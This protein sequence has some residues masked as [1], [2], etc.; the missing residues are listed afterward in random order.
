M[1]TVKKKI[2][3]KKR[4]KKALLKKVS[5]IELEVIKEDSPK[6]SPTELNETLPEKE[7][8]IKPAEIK[9]DWPKI[10]PVVEKKKK[11]PLFSI[12]ILAAGLICL[13]LLVYFWGPIFYERFFSQT[14]TVELP[15]TNV[16]A[17]PIISPANLKKILIPRLG[18]DAEIILAPADLSGSKNDWVE[19]QL[20]KGIVQ[21]PNGITDLKRQNLV[22][23][24]HSSSLHPQA[25]YAFVWVKLD[26]LKIGDEI[27]LISDK[28]E[29][30]NYK[31]TENP[32]TVS[33][34]EI[35]VVKVDKAAGIIT[36]VTCWPPGT[37]SKRMV[38]V[39][40]LVEN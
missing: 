21:Y 19:S 9:E 5:Q 8:P 11:R 3:R 36:L 1:V 10:I 27:V 14:K 35:E 4:I 15:N 25:K 29:R 34:E 17:E 37:T 30:I 26:Q 40:E 23:F 22:L 18:T 16:V 28:E 6:I 32:R 13:I 7:N 31:V 12:L 38:V 39:G 2:V 33:A 24:G 20:D